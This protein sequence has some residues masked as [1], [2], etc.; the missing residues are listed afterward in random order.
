MVLLCNPIHPLKESLHCESR[1]KIKVL[2]D[3]TPR[4][5]LWSGLKMQSSQ[6]AEWALTYKYN[7]QVRIT[8][9]IQTILYARYHVV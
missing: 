1:S 3:R 6:E 8:I 7:E 5:G 9:K 4:I 2:P